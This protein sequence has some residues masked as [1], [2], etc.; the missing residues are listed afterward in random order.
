[1][2]ASQPLPGSSCPGTLPALLTLR[3]ALDHTFLSSW[4]QLQCPVLW[5]G[6]SF[7]PQHLLSSEPGEGAPAASSGAQRPQDGC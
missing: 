4:T 2:P 1:M 5:G 7:L 3:S 6:F